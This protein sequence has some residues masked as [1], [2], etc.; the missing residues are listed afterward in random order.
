LAGKEAAASNKKYIG[1]VHCIGEGRKIA[2]R[3]LKGEEA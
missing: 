3:P 2:A 1:Y